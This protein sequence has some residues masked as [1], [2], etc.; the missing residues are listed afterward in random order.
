[1]CLFYLMMK[2][3]EGKVYPIPRFRIIT[4]PRGPHGSAG[5][6]QSQ[7]LAP[8][9]WHM[10]RYLTSHH[11]FRENPPKKMVPIMWKFPDHPPWFRWTGVFS[12]N[13]EGIIWPGIQSWRWKGPLRIE[14]GRFRQD[15][16]RSTRIWGI[17]PSIDLIN[18]ING[19]TVSRF[20]KVLL[21]R[22]NKYGIM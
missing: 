2:D 17:E 6:W 3:D 11:P 12:M 13:G 7:A 19:I 8:S 18:W 16:H 15:Q 5:S 10:A 9:F 22:I 1:M 14:E 21:S 4:A 20:L